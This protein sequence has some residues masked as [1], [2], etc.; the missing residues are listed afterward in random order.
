MDTR[1]KIVAPEVLAAPG[2]N[3]PTVAVGYF[4]VLQ[5]AH[6]AELETLGGPGPLVVVVLPLAGELLS[7]RSRAELIAALRSV[8]YVVVA[9]DSDPSRLL[10]LLQPSRVARLETE[11]L[12]R[13][14]E[15]IDEVRR[16]H[17]A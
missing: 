14:Q 15:L 7:Q 11:D 5:P 17:H 10:D 13:R 4:D 16:R 8:D 12:R 1:T 6:V 2:L 3:A 9:E